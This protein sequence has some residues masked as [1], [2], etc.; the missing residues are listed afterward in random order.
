[1][2]GS[3]IFVAAAFT[4]MIAEDEISSLRS[5][6]VEIFAKC[7][8]KIKTMQRF[9]S[10]RGSAESLANVA[11]SFDPEIETLLDANYM[12][13]TLEYNI[14][15]MQSMI[16]SDWFPDLCVNMTA[17][18]RTEL[19]NRWRNDMSTYLVNVFDSIRV[20]VVMAKVVQVSLRVSFCSYN[21]RW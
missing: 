11:V 3:W 14:T 7:D 13:S 20:N 10:T 15:S 17:A 18:N 8:V 4:M 16:L 2:V 21:T 9:S 1:L 6:G 5:I 19:T 12:G